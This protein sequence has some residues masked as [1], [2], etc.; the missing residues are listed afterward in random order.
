MQW[1]KCSSRLQSLFLLIAVFVLPPLAIEIGFTQARV[2]HSETP[3]RTITTI[4]EKD[5]PSEQTFAIRIQIS[6]PRIQGLGAPAT[7]SPSEPADFRLGEDPVVIVRLSPAFNQTTLAYTIFQ[8]NIPE[9]TEIFQLSVDPDPDTPNNPD[10]DCDADP[11]FRFNG[12]DCFLDLQVLIL[13]G[14]GEPLLFL[15]ILR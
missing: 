14:D 3:Q 15:G 1:H 9:G 12:S 2:N 5:R 7:A 8:D 10:F 11:R 4:L 13:D 6:T